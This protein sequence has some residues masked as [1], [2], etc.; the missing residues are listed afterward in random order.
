MLG[1]R[2]DQPIE[3]RAA[4]YPRV[5]SRAVPALSVFFGISAVGAY[6]LADGDLVNVAWANWGTFLGAVC[7]L[8]ASILMV[9][10]GRHA[11]A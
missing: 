9:P 3:H 8:V 5:T 7:F 10:E 1:E 6:V 4:R 2:L 11:A